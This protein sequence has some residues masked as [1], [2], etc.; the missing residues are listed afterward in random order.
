AQ[1]GAVEQVLDPGKLPRAPHTTSWKA[2]KRGFLSK[3]D[4]EALGRI[5]VELGGGRKRASDTIDPGVG[6]IFHR[7][8]GARVL[9]GD[10]LVTVHYSNPSA[11]TSLEERFHAAVEISGVRKPVP[12]LILEQI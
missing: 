9:A 1:G 8:L 5:L 4:T 10:P 12:K 11:I 7:K 6:M 2:R 3:M